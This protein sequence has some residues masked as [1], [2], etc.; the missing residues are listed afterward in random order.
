MTSPRKWSVIRLTGADAEHQPSGRLS[1]AM[2][3]YNEYKVCRAEIIDG[4]TYIENMLELVLCDAIVGKDE[5]YRTRLRAS[6]FAGEAFT[7]FQKWKALRSLL[8]KEPSLMGEVIPNL[9]DHIRG[10]S[11]V[12]KD[13][14]KF[15]H[16]SIIVN[17]NTL[18]VQL[19]YFEGSKQVLELNEAAIEVI[20]KRMEE[21]YFWLDGLHLKF[22]DC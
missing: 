1:V 21:A 11:E 17:E 8:E 18:Q 15:A 9:K 7:F 14:N 16:G 19:Q 4:A 13:R 6:M 22:Y 20:I 10:L 3:R 5:T 2:S 12:I